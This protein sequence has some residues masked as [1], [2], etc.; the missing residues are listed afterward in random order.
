M[1]NTGQWLVSTV[2]AVVNM[3]TNILQS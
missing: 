1:T 3:N 2:G